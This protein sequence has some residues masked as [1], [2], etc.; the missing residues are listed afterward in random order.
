MITDHLGIH[1]ETRAPRQEAVV[2]ILLQAGGIGRSA[3]AVSRRHHDELLQG[4]DI[5]SAGNEL[6]GQP[7]EELGMGR[8]FT[9]A[10]E[11]FAGLH[12]TRAKAA[13]PKAVHRNPRREGI[14]WIHQPACQGQ[15]IGRES[16]GQGWEY[17]RGSRLNDLALG[18]EVAPEM[19]VGLARLRLRPLLH[20]QRG[21]L[22]AGTLLATLLE[23][24]E[25]AFQGPDLLRGGALAGGQERRLLSRA[26]LR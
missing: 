14:G 3:L 16:H 25:F 9:L 26:F 12:Q 19:D 20:D 17:R 11:V 18:Q 2:E 24:E 7:I 1:A 13:L 22:L 23:H 6:G 15:S 10:A 21:E 5:P 4:F 8:Q